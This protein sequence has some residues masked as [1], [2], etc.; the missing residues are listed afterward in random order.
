LSREDEEVAKEMA[1]LE[2]LDL[3]RN[4]DLFEPDPTAKPH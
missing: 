4:L 1:L 2:H 3:L